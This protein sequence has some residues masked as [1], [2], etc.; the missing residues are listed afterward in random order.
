MVKLFWRRVRIV[1]ALLLVVIALS[2]VW[3]IY[4]KERESRQ[5]RD[6]SE[7][8]LEDLTQQQILL[9]SNIDKLQTERGKEEVLRD[10]YQ[11]AKPGEQMMIIVE[12]QQP[13]AATSSNGFLQL[14]H[15]FLPF[16]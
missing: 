4:Q 2:G 12:P 6:D 7:R 1:A 10:Q 8:Q 11:V 14:V 5:L 15:K 16:W 9:Q 3:N 13:E